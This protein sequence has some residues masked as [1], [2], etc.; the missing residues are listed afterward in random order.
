MQPEGDGQSGLAVSC[1]PVWQVSYD[2]NNNFDFESLKTFGWLPLKDKEQTSQL[3]EERIKRAVN[4][5]LQSKGYKMVADNP[6]FLILAKAG[7]R[8]DTWTGGGYHR[9]GWATQIESGTLLL[10]FIDAESNNLIWRG[11]SSA[12]LDYNLTPE[13]LNKLAEAIVQDILKKFPPPHSQ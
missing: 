2:Y 7:T 10:E 3:V 4:N 8:T 5:D 13:K 6:D 9:G 1:S 11:N 12:V